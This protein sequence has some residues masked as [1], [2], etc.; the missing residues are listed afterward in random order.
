MPSVLRRAHIVCLP[1]HYREGVPKV[2]IEAASCGRSIVTTDVPGCR[3]IVNHDETGFLVAP[4]D[5][6]GLA[7]RIRDLLDNPD[8]RREM[9]QNGRSRVEKNFTAAQ[10]AETIVGSYD[11]LLSKV[12]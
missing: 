3:E 11:R 9:G 12:V 5:P 4:K 6:E 8:L 1:S 2:L 10:V 7:R